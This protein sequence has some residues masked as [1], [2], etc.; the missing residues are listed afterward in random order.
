MNEDKKFSA[1][2]G[3]IIIEVKNLKKVY[4]KHVVLSDINTTIRK[5]EVISI[6]G[7]S[8]CGKSTFLRSLNLLENPTEGHI[9]FHGTD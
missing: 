6:I 9:L 1:G 8:G 3:D 2:N 4:D 5:G 7:P